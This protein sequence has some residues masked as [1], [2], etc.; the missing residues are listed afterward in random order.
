VNREVTGQT[1]TPREHAPCA[2]ATG[3]ATASES[4][5]PGVGYG[6]KCVTRS[7]RS[8]MYSLPSLALPAWS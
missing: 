3:T 2:S 1:Q 7:E 5:A 6:T 8:L 4:N